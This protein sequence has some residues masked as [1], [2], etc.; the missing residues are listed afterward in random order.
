MFLITYTN[1]LSVTEAA[2]EVVAPARARSI[3]VPEVCDG[4]DEL[5]IRPKVEGRSK[6]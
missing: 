1:S 6:S 4:G 3:E 2:A 5:L